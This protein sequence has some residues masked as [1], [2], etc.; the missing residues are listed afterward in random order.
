MTA[1]ELAALRA[2]VEGGGYKGA[3]HRLGLTEGALKMRLSRWRRREGV[4]TNAELVFRYRDRIE[5]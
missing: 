3:A 2:I 1:D 5:A 4:D